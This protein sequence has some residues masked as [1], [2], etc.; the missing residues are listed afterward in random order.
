MSSQIAALG[1]ELAEIR[2]TLRGLNAPRLNRSSIEGGAIRA[3][4]NGLPGSQ[5]TAQLGAQGDGTHMAASLSGPVPP[6]PATAVLAPIP[7]GLRVSW[8]GTWDT[9]LVPPLD[10]TRVEVHLGTDP[11]LAAVD[12]SAL[13]S[14]IESPRGGSVDVLLPQDGDYYARLVARSLCGKASEPSRIAGPATP[15]TVSK[16]GATSI[17]PGTV[18]AEL[19]T[20]DLRSVL[21]SLDTRLASIQAR[22]AAAGIS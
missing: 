7:G 18:G 19:L 21:E 4:A 5:Q 3:Y 10:L 13:K 20:P 15:G 11:Q 2:R 9:A 14:T 8:D 22:L 6:R 1:R 17:N 16:D 12:A